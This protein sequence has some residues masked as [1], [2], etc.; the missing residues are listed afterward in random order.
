MVI[1]AEH[2]VWRWGKSGAARRLPDKE[3]GQEGNSTAVPAVALAGAR[4]AAVGIPCSGANLVAEPVRGARPGGSG[5]TG[6]AG[7]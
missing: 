5:R 2:E 4:G 3:R 6:S 7:S 1:K